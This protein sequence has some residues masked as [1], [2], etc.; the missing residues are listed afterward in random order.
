M[1]LIEIDLSKGYRSRSNLSDMLG[2]F[3]VQDLVSSLRP[4]CPPMRRVA[5]TDSEK[6]NAMEYGLPSSHAL[7]KSLV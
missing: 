7:S 3:I 2:F 1:L 4:S 6:E 5:S